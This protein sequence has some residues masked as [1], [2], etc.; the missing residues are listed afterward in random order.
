MRILIIDDE[1]AVAD[2]LVMIL[3]RKGHKA[4]A[5]YDGGVAL[6]RFESFAP[7]C[8]ISDVMVPGRNGV[9]VC[10]VIQAKYPNCHI[11]L[12]S[13]QAET[14]DLIQK[15]RAAGHNWELLIKPFSPAELLAKLN[16]LELTPH[17]IASQHS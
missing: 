1:K 7:D 10:A 8:V 11:L 9:D 5:V 2:T 4:E 3:E 14:S 12:F 15:A 6:E 17:P 16:S 13:G